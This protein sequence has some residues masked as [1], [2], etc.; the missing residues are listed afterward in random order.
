MNCLPVAR[1]L[2][3]CLLLLGLAL[4]ALA[5][6]KVGLVLGGGGARGAAHIGVLEVL[7]QLQVPVDCVAGTSFGAL[8]GAAWAAGVSPAEMRRAMTQANWG[9]MFQDNPDYTELNYRNKRLLQRYLPGSESGVGPDGVTYPPGAVTG[10]KIKLFINQLVRADRGERDLAALPVPVS[11]V[12]T[13]IGN[14]E[15]VVYRAGSLTQAMRASM[16][17]PGLMAPVVV[18]G[19][20]LVDGGLVDNLPIREVRE[21]CGAELVIAVNVGSPLLAPDEVGSLLTVSTQMVALLTEQNVT[22][23]LQQLRPGDVYIKPV[24]DGIGAGDFARHADAVE[25]GRVAAGWAAGA[26]QA[27]AVDDTAWAGWQQARTTPGLRHPWVDEVQVEGL[28]KANPEVVT[29]HLTQRPDTPLDTA[30]LNRDLLRAFGDGWYESVDYSLVTLRERHILR[31]TPVEKP[32]GPD[33]VRFAV[34]LDTTLSQGSSYS[35]RAGYQKT[36]LNRLGGEL[37]ASAEIGSRTGLELEWH[38]PLDARQRWFAELDLGAGWSYSD[39]FRDDDRVARYQVYRS[40]AELSLGR[41]LSRLGELR[42]SWSESVWRGDLETGTVLLP[43]GRQYLGGA[44]LSVDL[45]QLNRLYFPTDGW[46]A[47]LRYFHSKRGDYSRLSAELR[48]A[49]SIGAWVLG[50]RATY[51]G[52]PRGQLPIF[53]AGRLGGF[54]NLSGYASGQYVADTVRYGHLRAER[55]IGRLPLGLRGDMRLGLALELASV[56]QPYTEIA[57]TGLLD[58]A[59]IYIGGETPFGPVYLGYGQS[60]RGSANAYLFLGTP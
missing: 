23:S 29:R 53:E 36:W 40:Q 52:S 34:N 45:D 6:P 56:G 18:G 31:I 39:L 59:A 49:Y 57:R 44:A 17:V 27:L 7:E 9:D 28:A 26:L 37:L 46:A 38:Q 48:G 14:G 15:R 50:M 25:R 5:R 60:S 3:L 16:S 30:Q 32:W 55:I 4:P 42:V 41:S 33:Y 13:D 51:V 1:R 54:L 21:R 47:Q 19:R 8:V 12:A 10:Q 11:I 43:V 20:K 22:L 58:S 35:L 24:L 2:G